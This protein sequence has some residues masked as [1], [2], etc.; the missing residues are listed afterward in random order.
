MVEVTVCGCGQLQC[1]EADIVQSLVVNA[2]C[3]VCVLN[4]LVDRQC[5]VVGFYNCV[6]HLETEE[7]CCNMSEKFKYSIPFRVRAKQ[8]CNGLKRYPKLPC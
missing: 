7:Q 8:V 2:V 6:G 4:K 1:T 3:F 5:S